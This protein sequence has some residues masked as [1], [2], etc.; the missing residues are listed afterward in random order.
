MA[1]SL[2]QVIRERKKVIKNLRSRLKD[3]DTTVEKMERYLKAVAARKRV[4]PENKDLTW[5]MDRLSLAVNQ[6]SLFEQALRQGW[7][8]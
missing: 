8:I 4:V 6:L 7:A 2:T 3:V 1:E 5:I